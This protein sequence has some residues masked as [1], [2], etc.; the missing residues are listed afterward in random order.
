MRVSDRR[1]DRRAASASPGPSAKS[2]T[3]TDIFGPIAVPADRYWGAQ[4]QRSLEN[5]PIGTEPMPRPL[6]HAFGIIKRVAA[7]VNHELG[8]LDARRAPAIAKAA[9]EVSEGK[10]DDHF[11]L[12]V[13][14]TGS[15]TQTNMNVNEVIANRANELLGIPLGSKEGVHPNDHVNRAQST[16]DSFPTAMH[17]AA[18]IDVAEHLLP[19]IGKLKRVIEE[20]SASF[21]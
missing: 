12:V 19:E 13:W 21:Q 20:K 16:N 18:A 17:V 15:G 10:L 9:R 1:R 4:T 5:F 14:Q 2:R 3:E 11:P 7:E 6:I 8:L